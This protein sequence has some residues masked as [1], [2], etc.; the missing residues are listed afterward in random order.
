MRLIMGLRSPVAQGEKDTNAEAFPET[1][2]VDW[3]H[4]DDPTVKLPL[5][6]LSSGIKSSS[7]PS[8]P[9]WVPYGPPSI[10]TL[11]EEI[12]ALERYT[13]D[14]HTEKQELREQHENM[15]QEI[16][17]ICQRIKELRQ[18]RVC[19]RE[20][21]TREVAA[22]DTLQA[23]INSLEQ[24]RNELRGAYE[25]ELS[26][27]DGIHAELERIRSEHRH[28]QEQQAELEAA[29]QRFKLLRESRQGESHMLAGEIKEREQ[30][31]VQQR[32]QLT[33]IVQEQQEL[34]ERIRARETELAAL[35]AQRRAQRYQAFAL[36]STLK[37]G[38]DPRRMK[39]DAGKE[40]GK[41]IWWLVTAVIVAVLVLL[42]LK[43]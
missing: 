17:E 22:L 2:A 12:S 19:V 9:T 31:L 7:P 42:A 6:A 4:E 35:H 29:V 33:Q 32:Q 10:A 3:A 11:E 25:A 18:L 1:V 26:R 36:R 16:G 30:Q 43:H 14:R 38:A 15:Q 21:E 34:Q 5:A 13:V 24:A 37:S 27:H 40:Q 39:Q 23:R 8:H 28:Q 20:D 41:A